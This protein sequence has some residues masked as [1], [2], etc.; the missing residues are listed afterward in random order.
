MN[1]TNEL[2]VWQNG[3]PVVN[4]TPEQEFD[5]WQNGAPVVDMDEGFAPTPTT[6]VRRRACIF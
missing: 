2:L 5:V 3:A 1:E 6:V 4:L